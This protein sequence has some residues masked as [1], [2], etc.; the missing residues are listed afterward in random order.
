MVGGIFDEID[1][2]IRNQNFYYTRSI[3]S[4][5]CISSHA[6]VGLFYIQ[7]AYDELQLSS[8]TY[9]EDCIERKDSTRFQFRYS[10]SNLI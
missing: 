9:L 10:Y 5:F 3:I 8:V 4:L 2:Q 1:L 7:S 6:K